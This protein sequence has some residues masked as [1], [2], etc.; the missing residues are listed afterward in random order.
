MN[1]YEMKMSRDDLNLPLIY[2]ITGKVPER[3]F[4]DIIKIIC[5]YVFPYLPYI[6]NPT[7]AQ[8][9][10]GFSEDRNLPPLDYIRKKMSKEKLAV[11]RNRSTG[12]TNVNISKRICQRHTFN[13]NVVNKLSNIITNFL[14]FYLKRYSNI[15]ISDI[16]L[17]P[18]HGDILYY[19]EG[20]G[21][22]LH[23]DGVNDFPFGENKID[24]YGLP[25]WRMYTLLIGLDSNLTPIN[26]SNGDGNTVVYLPEQSFLQHICRLA[27]NNT[28]DL[29]EIINICNVSKNRHSFIESCQKGYFLLFSSEALH[30]SN[31]IMQK[32]GFKM[33]MKLDV[34]IKTDD[35]YNY[36]NNLN[37][38]MLECLGDLSD[39][40]LPYSELYMKDLIFDKR[41]LYH[42][43]L[44]N[45]HQ[46]NCHDCNRQILI[47]NIYNRNISKIF[48]K[49]K[50]NYNVCRIISEF[51]I[52][53]PKAE[54]CN[55][56]SYFNCSCSNCVPYHSLNDFQDD[57]DY[58]DHD[59]YD[60]NDYNY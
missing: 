57:S 12:I 40:S 25:T 28:D 56:F 55:P 46:C 6:K 3:N 18:S 41:Y 20:G 44:S 27:K 1:S 43:I 13:I 39:G 10:D 33:A 31:K 15:K 45:P 34:W 48:F 54:L 60:C 50:L 29:Y 24:E 16:K 36:L 37:S 17:D 30:A 42:N 11:I 53:I 26:L 4:E 52:N 22:D 8:I 23:V 19:E 32:N 49:S 47:S 7:Y 58:D 2:P 14:D 51:I 59:N 38:G 9:V 35:Q 5:N 21:F